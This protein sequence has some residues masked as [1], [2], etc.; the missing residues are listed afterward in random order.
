MRRTLIALALSAAGLAQAATVTFYSDLA[1][2]TAAISGSAQL[3]GFDSFA[4]GDDLTGVQ[5]LPGLTLSSNVGPV[6]V[7]GAQNTA[8]AFGPARQVGNAYYEGSYALPFLAAALD[9]TSFEADPNNA[10][11]AQDDG[12]LTFWFHDGTSQSWNIAG[13]LTGASIFAGIVSDSAITA[14]RWTEAHEASQGNEETGLDNFRVAMRTTTNELPLPGS[15]PLAA[16]ALAALPLAKR[17][18]R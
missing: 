13:N 15:L 8:A 12:T 16:L 4:T 2:W 10:S 9:I 3:Q 18:R 7:F 17:R 1:A 5:V 14:F 11:T 6:T